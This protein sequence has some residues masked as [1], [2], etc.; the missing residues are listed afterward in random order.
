MKTLKY[1]ISR[2]KE[3]SSW[4]SIF[5]GASSLLATGEPMTLIAALGAVL[6]DREYKFSSIG[7][8]ALKI[9]LKRLANK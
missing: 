6:P 1:I 8:Y 2:L 3:Q 9:A 4:V 5:A 7:K